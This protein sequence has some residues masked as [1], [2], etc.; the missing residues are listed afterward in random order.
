MLMDRVGELFDQQTK[1][2]IEQRRKMQGKRGPPL[3]VT[4]L[5]T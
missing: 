1:A 5:V 4:N 2:L 3:V